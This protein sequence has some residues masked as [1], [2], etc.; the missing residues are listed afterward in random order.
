MAVFMIIIGMFILG[1]NQYF[2]GR[3][4]SFTTVTGKSGQISYIKLKYWKWII[5]VLLVILSLYCS[6]LPL[7]SFALESICEIR[8]L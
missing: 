1:L 2:T 4:K 7:I 8:R 3:R 5:A 6:I